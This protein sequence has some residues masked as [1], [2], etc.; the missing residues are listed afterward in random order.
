MEEAAKLA[1]KMGVTMADLLG[2]A[3]LPKDVIA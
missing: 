3:E 2:G 1:D